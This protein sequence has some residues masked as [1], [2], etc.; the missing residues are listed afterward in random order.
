M[1]ATRSAIGRDDREVVAD[2]DDCNLA[3]RA[4]TLDFF[5]DPRL[6]DDVEPG[7]G[8]VHDDRRGLAHDGGRDR[9]A[10]LLTPRELVRVATREVAVTWEMHAFERLVHEGGAGSAVSVFPRDVADRVADTQGR[11]ERRRGVLRHVRDDLPARCLRASVS[12]SPVMRVPATST[13]PAV[14]RHPGRA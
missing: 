7:R 4:Q 3:L 14:I 2:E 8:L 6:R 5:Q 9:D 10:L 13:E 1:T 11:V 12:L